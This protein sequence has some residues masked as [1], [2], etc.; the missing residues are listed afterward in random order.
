MILLIV[1][2]HYY[3]SFTFFPFFIA[4]ASNAIPNPTNTTPPATNATVPAPPVT[5]NWNPCELGNVNLYIPVV[6]VSSSNAPSKLASTIFISFA[7]YW[8]YC[9]F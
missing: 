5:G 3:F 8:I 2:F 6:P 7:S 1:V 4:I 9:S